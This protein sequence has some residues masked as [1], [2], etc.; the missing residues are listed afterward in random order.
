MIHQQTRQEEKENVI[1]QPLHRP[2]IRTL[3]IWFCQRLPVGALHFSTPS[4]FHLPHGSNTSCC[5]PYFTH[6]WSRK[7]SSYSSANGHLLIVNTIT[8]QKQ[9]NYFYYLFHFRRDLIQ[10]WALCPEFSLN[11][12]LHLK[13]ISFHIW[14]IGLPLVWKPSAAP[15]KRTTC[16]WFVTVFWA[17]NKIILFLSLTAYKAGYDFC[18]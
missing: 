5:E 13:I 12:S 18:R 16:D 17:S 9:F 4:F 2:W 11:N 7:T 15:D 3:F 1:K 6:L 8:K 10:S 14:Y